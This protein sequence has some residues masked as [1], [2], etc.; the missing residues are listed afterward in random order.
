MKP[1]Q[2]Q[3]RAGSLPVPTFV[4]QDT[5]LPC[6]YLSGI[7]DKGQM[8]WIVQSANGFGAGIEIE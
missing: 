1:E 5:G 8:K 2:S 3:P 4:G 6:V 7:M